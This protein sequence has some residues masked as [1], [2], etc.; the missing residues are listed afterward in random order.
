MFR[1]SVSRLVVAVVFVLALVL[2]TAP[3][4]ALPLDSGS[5]FTDSSWLDAA[6][7]W[8][9][10]LFAGGDNPEPLQILAT[11]R[12]ITP[13]GKGNSGT[14]SSSCIDPYGRPTPCPEIP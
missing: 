2:S 11:G 13:W 4:Q 10:G 1:S 14:L 6:L 7:S 9:E 5:R 8:V 3:V 12:T